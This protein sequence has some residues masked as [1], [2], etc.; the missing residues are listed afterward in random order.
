V[1]KA[2]PAGDVQMLASTSESDSDVSL[3]DESKETVS[4]NT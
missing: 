2:V 3:D 4:S 1:S